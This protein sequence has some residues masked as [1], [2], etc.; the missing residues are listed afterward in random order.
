MGITQIIDQF[1]EKVHPYSEGKP[2]K[3]V[4]GQIAWVPTVF[5][6]TNITIIEARRARREDHKKLS[7]KFQ[8]LSASHF[9]HKNQEELPIPDVKLWP[10]EELMPFKAKKRPCV[11]I[12]RASDD[13]S[14]IKEIKDHQKGT[15][16]LFIPIYST[17]RN[18]EHK[19]YHQKIVQSTKY[20]QYT[21][22]LYLPNCKIEGLSSNPLKEGIARI[23][24]MFV[25]PPLV[26]NVTPTDVK[27]HD[28]YL[29]FFMFQIREY[30]F[31]ETDINLKEMRELLEN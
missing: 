26:P 30:I 15:A 9:S 19:G 23:D 10:G 6:G 17:H 31:Q 4:Q 2:E 3:L 29:R 25:T 11:Y 18:D 22:L 21:H 27:I 24:R 8:R 1:Y 16:F 12:T 28:E 7:I 13:L 5:L 14:S 20:L